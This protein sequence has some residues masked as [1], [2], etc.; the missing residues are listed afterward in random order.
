MQYLAVL[1]VAALVFG[2]C[3]LFDKGFQKPSIIRAC[4]SGSTSVMPPSAPS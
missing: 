1:M 4:P 2:A 3:Y